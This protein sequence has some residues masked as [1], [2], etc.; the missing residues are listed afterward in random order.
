M[1]FAT[2]LRWPIA[3]ARTD[4][5]PPP[6][7]SVPRPQSTAASARRSRAAMSSG[8]TRSR[9]C[10]IRR[11]ECI[12][13]ASEMGSHFGDSSASTAVES[14]LR[15]ALWTNS[16]GAVR[17]N[18]GC[19]KSALTRVFGSYRASLLPVPGSWTALPALTNAVLGVVGTT[20][21][22]SLA[23][24]SRGLSNCPFG[25]RRVHSSCAGRFSASRI[26]AARAVT[27][28]EP[29]PIAMTASACSSPSVRAASSTAGTGLLERTAL[30]SPT[31]TGPSALRRSSIA[32]E[33]LTE[34]PQMTT[35]RLQPLRWSSRASAARLSSPQKSRSSGAKC[36]NDEEEVFEFMMRWP[37]RLRD[38][39]S[40]S[41]RPD[42]RRAD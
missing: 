22:G 23:A 5:R 16:D 6:D 17:R 41:K 20:N 2:L 26:L 15:L 24:P 33:V 36:W 19:R 38:R 31:R 28:A 9:C 12:S 11:S 25:S 34:R 27:A 29:P 37:W 4:A 21:W 10:A 13:I 39:R 40:G 8:D 1:P 18:S 7:C 14:V 3:C 32:F 30:D 35:A 42:M